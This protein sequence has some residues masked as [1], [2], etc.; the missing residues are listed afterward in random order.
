MIDRKSKIW[1]LLLVSFLVNLWIVVSF[2]LECPWYKH[3]GID[4]AGCGAT[5]MLFSLLE[6][7]FYQA[8]RFNP[9]IFISLLLVLIYLIYVLICK[10]F[11]R[12][13]L[14]LGF[15]TAMLFIVCMIIF[16]ILRNIN[17]FEFL[18]PTIVS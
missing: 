15:K 3:F 4:C 7:D 2:E 16:M 18:K 9:F 5:R 12:K 10:V 1:L 8:F 6:F 11:K 14:K 17:G 13:Y